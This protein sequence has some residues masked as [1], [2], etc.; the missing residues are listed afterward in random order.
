MA[1]GATSKVY[2]SFEWVA[3]RGL[4]VSYPCGHVEAQADCDAWLEAHRA[5]F[6]RHGGRYDLIV[7]VDMFSMA[8]A[9]F[10]EFG[11]VR[12]IAYDTYF[13]YSV[14]VTPP[15]NLSVPPTARA[16]YAFD[17]PSAMDAIDR[18]RQE[19]GPR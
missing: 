16:G 13:R 10:E 7:V 4:Y 1:G 2:V 9:M 12:E 5:L 14:R 8:R 6:E 19:G 18:M 15:T 11:A 3:E 17:I